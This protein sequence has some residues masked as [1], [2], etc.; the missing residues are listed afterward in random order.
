MVR[1]VWSLEAFMMDGT[2]FPH[3][4]HEMRLRTSLILTLG[5]MR[6]QRLSALHSACCQI[7]ECGGAAVW[8]WRSIDCCV[9]RVIH[10]VAVPRWWRFFADCACA[11]ACLWLPH[12]LAVCGALHLASCMRAVVPASITRVHP[13]PSRSCFL[14]CLRQKG[15]ST[16]TR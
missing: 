4:M 1:D 9:V 16:T 6:A 11:L 15:T 14:L 3:D 12:L 8:C 7:A 10:L 5:F 13:P 2:V